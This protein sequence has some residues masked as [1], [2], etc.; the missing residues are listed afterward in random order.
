MNLVGIAVYQIDDNFAWSI[1]YI[2]N[3]NDVK[4][5]KTR[6][7]VSLQRFGKM[8]RKR[9]NKYTFIYLF[10]YFIIIL[11]FK[12]NFYTQFRKMPRSLHS[13]GLFN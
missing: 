11:P 13:H 12:L 9:K 7:V 5:I 1:L 2:D 4:M 8:A 3:S 10:I 6:E